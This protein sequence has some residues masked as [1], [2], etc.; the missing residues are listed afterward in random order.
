MAFA[1]FMATT[2]GRTLRVVAGIVLI[3]L[4]LMSV[5]GTRGIVLAGIGLVPL[6]AGLF[7]V[8]LIAPLLGM[9]LNGRA[10]PHR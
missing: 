2:I 8:C 3:V 6:V 7:N 1:Q 5:Q 9:P 10:V 4:G